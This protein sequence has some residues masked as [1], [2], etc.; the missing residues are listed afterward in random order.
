MKLCSEHIYSAS[1]LFKHSVPGALSCPN[2][3]FFFI[4]EVSTARMQDIYDGQ[5]SEKF[6]FIVT[7]IFISVCLKYDDCER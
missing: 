7:F 4:R 2:H 1:N 6:R 3:F 5:G